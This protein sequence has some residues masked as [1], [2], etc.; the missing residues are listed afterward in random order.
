MGDFTLSVFN[1]YNVWIIFF[2]KPRQ[3][4]EKMLNNSVV[5]GMKSES[6]NTEI[7]Y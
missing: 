1:V 7:V 4:R 6:L 5:F 2:F 3:K